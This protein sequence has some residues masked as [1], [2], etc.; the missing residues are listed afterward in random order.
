MTTTA[1]QR[2]LKQR[3]R[4]RV[5][6]LRTTGTTAPVYNRVVISQRWRVPVAASSHR[7]PFVTFAETWRALR[8]SLRVSLFRSLRTKHCRSSTKFPAVLHGKYR[9][10]CCYRSRRREQ[11]A[12]PIPREN[13]TLQTRYAERFAIAR[14]IRDDEPPRDDFGRGKLYMLPLRETDNRK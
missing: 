5:A 12:V 1:E 2:Q 11:R 7:F 4:R 8:F 6:R 10:R 14:F 13:P 9:R 3:R